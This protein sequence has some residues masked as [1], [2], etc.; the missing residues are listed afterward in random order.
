MPVVTDDLLTEPKRPPMQEHAQVLVFLVQKEFREP[1]KA[2]FAELRFHHKVIGEVYGPTP[3][4]VL[5]KLSRA[6]AAAGAAE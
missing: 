5:L 3:A 1:G 2:V 4:E 6:L